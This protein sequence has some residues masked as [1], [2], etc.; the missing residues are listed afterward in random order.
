MSL[1]SMRTFPGCWVGQRTLI[2]AEEIED[3]GIEEGHTCGAC[4]RV[5]F[6]GP[7]SEL[8]HT[9]IRCGCGEFNQL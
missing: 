5:I 9:V 2:E 7:S 6:T 3:A 4:G 8:R 1:V